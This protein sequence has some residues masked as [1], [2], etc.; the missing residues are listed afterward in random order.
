[1]TEH[2]I[3]EA[4]AAIITQRIGQT[5][6]F[7]R[8][9]LDN[10]ALLE[11][12]P[13]KSR[14]VFRDIIVKEIGLRLTAFPSPAHPGMWEARITGPPELAKRAQASAAPQ[15]PP[16]G[17]GESAERALDALEDA[18]HTDFFAYEVQRAAA[19]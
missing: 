15:T 12:I 17:I 4:E 6:G 3:D 9:V 10:P 16:P 18:L 11:I 19:R 13:D 7:V 8:D 2:D 14:L 5:F 1:M